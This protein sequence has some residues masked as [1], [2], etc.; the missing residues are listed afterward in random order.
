MLKQPLPADCLYQ[1]ETCPTLVH[2]T[3][4]V[5]FGMRIG[6]YL[7][8]LRL[9]DEARERALADGA[10]WIKHPLLDKLKVDLA[11]LLGPEWTMPNSAHPQIAEY[12]GSAFAAA[13]WQARNDGD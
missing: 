1:V 8:L 2:P 6:T 7:C 5:V 13:G 10:V 12:Y 3:T 9:S 11:S 4:G